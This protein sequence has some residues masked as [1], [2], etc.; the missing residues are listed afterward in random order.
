MSP[1]RTGWRLIEL[2]IE[3]WNSAKIAWLSAALAYYT[4]FSL[5][6]TLIIITALG[7]SLFG[8]EFVQ[9]HI[10]E[11]VARLM[12]Q[13]T[14]SAIQEM[15][16]AGQTVSFGSIHSLIGLGILLFAAANVFGNLKE[17]LN[18]IWEAKPRELHWVLRYIIAR[19]LSMLMVLVIGVIL[20]ALVLVDVTLVKFGRLLAEYVPAFS[21]LGLWRLANFLA[22]FVVISL[23]FALIYKYLPDTPIRFADVWPGACISS[24]LF[25]VGKSLIGLYLGKSQLVSV[26][27]AAS[28]FVVILVWVYYSVQIL[29]LGAAFSFQYSRLRRESVGEL[30]GQ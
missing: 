6:P 26:F 17:T 12:G 13:S 5:A 10:I 14:A 4:L 27:G 28:S 18:E 16:D 11:R 23:L 15:I 1:L 29:F 24:L 21:S 8:R 7:G 3:K 25:T 30:P 19:A 22:S 20:L 9:G 2:T